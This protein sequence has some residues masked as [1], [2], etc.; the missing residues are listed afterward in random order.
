MIVQSTSGLMRHSINP[1]FLYNMSICSA[2]LY[3]LGLQDL[4]RDFGFILHLSQCVVP[5]VRAANRKYTKSLY[6]CRVSFQILRPSH[7]LVGTVLMGRKIERIASPPHTLT[8]NTNEA[9]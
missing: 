9:N 3:P 8:I 1:L 2:S 5:R 6:I 4:I 7:A